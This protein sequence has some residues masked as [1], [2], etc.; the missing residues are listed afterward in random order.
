[1]YRSKNPQK[2][3]TDSLIPEKVYT[4]LFFVNGPGT[5]LFG[6]IVFMAGFTRNALN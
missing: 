3:P 2:L 1:M 4:K 5:D 6:K